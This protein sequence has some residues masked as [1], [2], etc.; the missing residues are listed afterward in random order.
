MLVIYIRHFRIIVFFFKYLHFSFYQNVQNH[1]IVLILYK[2]V[3]T[4]NV[5]DQH[6]KF[7]I[8]YSNTTGIKLTVANNNRL[9]VYSIDV[10]Q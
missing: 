4:F 2:R 6:V 3:F 7:L 1:V 5:K 10:S 9:M 8:R